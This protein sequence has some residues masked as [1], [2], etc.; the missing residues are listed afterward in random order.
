MM[1]EFPINTE[2][3][4]PPIHPGEFLADELE[5]LEMSARQL[6]KALNVPANRIT[7]ILK[8]DCD[9]AANTAIRLGQYFG[10]SPHI[11]LNLQLK[12]DFKIERLEHGEEIEREVSRRKPSRSLN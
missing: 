6:A 11:W 3:A 9:L 1:S 5:E 12:Y 4:F 8:G 7:R 2:S 10:T